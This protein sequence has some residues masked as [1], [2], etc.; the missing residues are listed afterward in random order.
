MTNLPAA[1]REQL[2]A[3]WTVDPF[4]KSER[5]ESADGSVRYLFTLKDGKQ[6]EAVYMPYLNRRT[7]CI[8]SMVGCP[9]GCA[10]C[11]TGAMGFGRNLNVA[12]IVGQL[13]AVARSEERRVG[14][15]GRRRRGAG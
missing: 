13:L 9:A 6:T 15:E 8:S 3:E 12:E 11:A 14:Q 2:A 1:W 4:V 10:F 5:F 7:I